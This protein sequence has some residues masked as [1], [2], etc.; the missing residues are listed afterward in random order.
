MQEGQLRTLL[1]V[2]LSSSSS[3]SLYLARLGTVYFFLDFKKLFMREDLEQRTQKLST[4]NYV[5]QKRPDR[6]CEIMREKENYAND[7]RHSGF[8]RYLTKQPWRTVKKRDAAS[9]LVAFFLILFLGALVFVG[10]F[11]ASVF[12]GIPRKPTLTPTG[13]PSEFP[14]RCATGNLKQT[15]PENYPAKHNPTTNPDRPSNL[16]STCPSYFQWIHDDLRHWKE[17]GITQDMIERARKTAHFRLV[18]VN[19][20]AYVEKYRQ[21]I[22]T[23]D[24]FTLWGILQ[25]LRLYPGRL[26]DL[27]LM[28]DCDDRPVIPS[29]HFRGPNAAPPPL[30]RYCSDWQ[31]L[32]IVFPD[33]SFWGWAETNIRPWKNLLKEIKEGNSR[34]K[35]KDRTPYA[36]WRGNP[37][38]SPIRQDLL[39]CNV[40]EQND[41]NT[42]L[43]VQDWIKQSKEGYRESNLQ[44]QCTHRLGPPDFHP[45]TPN[46]PEETLTNKYV[47]SGYKEAVVEGL[48][49]GR[50]I[51]HTQAPNFTSPVVKKCKEAGQVYGVP[52]S[53]SLL[54]K[55]GVFPEQR[56]CV[57]DLKKK[58]IEGLSQ[59]HKRLRSLADH[60]P[61]GYRKRSL[62][63]VLI[64][65]NVPLL[66]ATWFIKVTYLNQV[67]PSSTSISSG[68]SDKNQVS[69]TEHWTKDV[70][71]YLQSLLDEYLSR[72]QYSFCSTQQR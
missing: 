1:L 5:H 50:E 42:R 4:C 48:E 28:F 6:A 63:E 18:I 70:V 67:R 61:H 68:T 9:V 33:W 69:R 31:S 22:Q 20:K 49:E 8:E 41:W 53:G 64:R 2:N 72:K 10:W 11:D 39:K 59:P 19:G 13:M 25:L 45:Q 12:R 14:L 46:C 26:P 3:S 40:S 30:F 54:T 35:W 66:R 71:D 29:K 60:V 56:P 17:T 37:W 32:D 15:C 7:I 21:S 62:L 47:A 57:E 16:T 52:L 43:Y 55:P 27:E 65:N 58:W 34:T 36:Y 44:D 24:M 23:R 51:S 38:V